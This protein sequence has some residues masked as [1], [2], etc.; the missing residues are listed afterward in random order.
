MIGEPDA[1]KP[2]VRFDKGVQEACDTSERVGRGVNR[3]HLSYST[4][5]VD[6]LL[7]PNRDRE[8]TFA[9][10]I[11]TSSEP[12]RRGTPATVKLVRNPLGI[13]NC[14]DQT[15][16][17]ESGTLCAFEI[18]AVPE[19][20]VRAR[21]RGTGTLPP[22]APVTCGGDVTPTPWKNTVTADP[23]GAGLSQLLIVPFGFSA[24]ARC[25]KIAVA[26]Q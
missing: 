24:N 10:R 22:S 20:F 13:C 12:S 9:Y 17:I 26:P 3:H 2:H 14:T 11:H 7:L 23:R 21:F 15:P 18:I 19:V 5:S 1:G 8:R 4:G 25:A 6:S 16:E